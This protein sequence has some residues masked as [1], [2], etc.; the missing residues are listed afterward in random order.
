MLVI[1]HLGTN[2]ARRH[3]TLEFGMVW[4]AR[5]CFVIISRFNLILSTREVLGKVISG[6]RRRGASSFSVS[7]RI[8]PNPA[9]FP[10][11]A[12]KI[13]SC[14]CFSVSVVTSRSRL[15]R[16]AWWR[17]EYTIFGRAW[18]R[19]F[20]NLLF[21]V[22]SD[23]ASPPRKDIKMVEDLFVA[24]TL[25]APHLYLYDFCSIRSACT[26]FSI[27]VRFHLLHSRCHSLAMLS[28]F[29]FQK[30][31]YRGDLCYE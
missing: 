2:F 12:V 8:L 16:K 10:F 30:L 4:A 9:A 29:E 20:M 6:E 7:L 31:F 11:S 19:A 18:R 17:Q 21:F 27:C 5:A 23:T 22:C 14:N 26:S 28:K 25:A 24:R 13:L 1:P 15:G 3:L